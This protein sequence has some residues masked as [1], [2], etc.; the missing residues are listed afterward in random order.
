[1]NLKYVRSVFLNQV[2]QIQLYDNRTHQRRIK[3]VGSIGSHRDLKIKIIYYKKQ[4]NMNNVVNTFE[5]GSKAS[6]RLLNSSIVL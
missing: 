4:Q 6:S 5:R 1:M 2:N 3:C